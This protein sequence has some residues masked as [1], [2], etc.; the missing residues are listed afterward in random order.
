MAIYTNYGRYLKA[1]Q[2][3]DSLENRAYMVFGIGNV[4][5]DDETYSQ[6][7][8]IA[9]FNT[10]IINSS[11]E[12][13][14]FTDPNATQYFNGGK[15]FP[16]ASDSNTYL[17]K[18]KDLIP[19]FPCV[20]KQP[21]TS[22]SAEEIFIFSTTSDNGNTIKITQNYYFN[23]YIIK[24]E[25][26]LTYKLYSFIEYNDINSEANVNPNCV[27]S[28]ITI[29]LPTD[30]VSKQ[31]FAELYLRGKAVTHNNKRI[32][33]PQN[34][35]I[36]K[37]IKSPAGL[38][39][40]I[41]CRI[42]YVKPVEDSESADSFWYGDRYWK[43]VDPEVTF[44]NYIDENTTTYPHHIM[45]SAIINPRQLCD[46]L[47]IDQLITPRQLAIYKSNIP[48]TVEYYGKLAYKL[49]D[50]VFN[51]GQYAQADL[52]NDG[53]LPG[54]V[55]GEG[56]VPVLNLTLPVKVDEH[57]SSRR[58]NSEFEFILHDYIKGS[59][60]EDSHALDQFGYIIGF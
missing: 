24:D 22:E 53:K 23:Y 3:K 54:A 17:S 12:N 8:P 56:S 13:N 57:E 16:F 28:P 52:D 18:C 29:N 21:D 42:S 34:D 6:Q 27:N 30:N 7:L 51:F 39:G 46:E 15:T 33:A 4:F 58:P 5:W 44:E 59:V 31:I 2:F 37:L 14:Q 25:T 35:N 9:P 11:V 38:L 50:Y 48:E 20:W 19:P 26:T 32:L 47:A 45:L 49:G 1:K 60:R 36:D 10:S 41:K 43:I 55:A 40:A